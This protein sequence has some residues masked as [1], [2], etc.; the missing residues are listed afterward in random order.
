[1]Y[2]NFTIKF[3]SLHFTCLEMKQTGELVTREILGKG[4][5]E[6]KSSNYELLHSRGDCVLRNL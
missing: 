6:R 2:E 5:T 4:F 3:L 1:M